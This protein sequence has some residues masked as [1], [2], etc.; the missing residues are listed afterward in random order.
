MRRAY[1]VGVG[2]GQWVIV[3]SNA[4]TQ[5]RQLARY[6][7]MIASV[8]DTEHVTIVETISGN[9]WSIDPLIIIKGS[10][11]QARWFADI[12]NT[13]ITVTESGYSN[14]AVS[15]LWLQHFDRLTQD[16]QQG[17]CRLLIVDGYD[18]HLTCQIL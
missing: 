6:R 14:D 5:D 10:I 4:Q 11:I 18:S 1:A 13:P 12:K 9:G 15:F 17:R 2:R 16:R 7:H 8:F 3:P